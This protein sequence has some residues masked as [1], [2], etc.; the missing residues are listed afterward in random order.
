MIVKRIHFNEQV[1]IETRTGA[2]GD[3]TESYN[4][5]KSILVIYKFKIRY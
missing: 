4:T 5:Y 3:G 2:F 1:I